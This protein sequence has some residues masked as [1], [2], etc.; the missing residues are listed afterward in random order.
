MYS[1]Y[2]SGYGKLQE[3]RGKIPY[4]YRLLHILLIFIEAEAETGP[5]C[6]ESCMDPSSK[7]KPMSRRA[8]PECPCCG[9]TKVLIEFSHSG[10]PG[11][12]VALAADP[13]LGPDFFPTWSF[14]QPKPAFSTITLIARWSL[15]IYVRRDKDTVGF[16]ALFMGCFSRS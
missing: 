8:D 4:S 13:F 14:L 7:R 6:R 12:I 10:G 1:G 15:A 3:R 5:F 16:R 9:V 2:P 11:A